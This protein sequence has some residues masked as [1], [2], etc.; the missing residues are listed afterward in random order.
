MGCVNLISI[1]AVFLPSTVPVTINMIGPYHLL[2]VHDL[3]LLLD[4][5]NNISLHFTT[6][7]VE[8]HLVG[9]AGRTGTWS[10]GPSLQFQRRGPQILE[11]KL[12]W[13]NSP[14]SLRGEEFHFVFHT[15]YN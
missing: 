10:F 1:G 13:T 4:A 8:K 6:W 5:K 3:F 14:Q 7:H 9:E 12:I 11:P 2:H 15:A